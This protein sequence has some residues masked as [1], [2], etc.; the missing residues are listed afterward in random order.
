MQFFIILF[1]VFLYMRQ[2]LTLQIGL[3][4]KH[5]V[6]QV[7]LIKNQKVHDTYSGTPTLVMCRS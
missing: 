4:T 6:E 7:I 1:Y 2:D 5:L 3:Q